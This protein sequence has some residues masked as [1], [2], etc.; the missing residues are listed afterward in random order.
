MVSALQIENL[1]AELSG[2][3]VLRGLSLTLEEGEVLGLIGPNGAGKTTLVRAAAGLIPHEGRIT[4]QGE[5]VEGM[6]RRERAQR[7]AY[8][9]QGAGSRWP[10][11]ARRVV[12]LGRLPHLAPFERPGAAEEAAITRAMEKADVM[13]FEGRPV[14]RLSGGERARVMLARALAVEAPILLVDEP[15][16]SLDPYHQLQIMDVLSGLAR[17][18][19]SVIAV[20]HDLALAARFCTRLALLDEGHL[21]AI[22]TP[23]EVLTD[24]QLSKVYRVSAE[25]FM[26][27]AGSLPVPWERQR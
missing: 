4:L 16:A 2:R 17:E 8:L 10:M 25:R 5:P 19:K 15:T 23:D 20:L 3:S 27:P 18:G 26:S 1:E 7:M 13:M 12:A 9:A 11:T 21:V 6:P 22:G 14:T 24:A